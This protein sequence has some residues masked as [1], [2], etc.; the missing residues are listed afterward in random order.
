[1]SRVPFVEVLNQAFSENQKNIEK[2]LDP[3]ETKSDVGTTTSTTRL[4]TATQERCRHP[5]DPLAAQVAEAIA[6]QLPAGSPPDVL[7]Y[8][9][10][11]SSSSSSGV[12][13]GTRTA[14]SR[15]NLRRAYHPALVW[16]AD[17]AAR[18]GYTQRRVLRALRQAGPGQT[19]E[20]LR[21]RIL[22]VTPTAGTVHAAL[23]ELRAAGLGPPRTRP[24]AAPSRAGR[25][26]R[27]RGTAPSP[28]WNCAARTICGTPSRPGRR[29]P[30]SPPGH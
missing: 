27:H 22:G 29:T 13:A 28:T 8:T 18:L 24:V 15:D 19:P 12:A 26:A 3:V 6:R 25:P 14:L 17:P 23:C 20:T 7:V 30:A 5:R 9:G 10:G 2:R 4:Q 11:D 16:V 1:M 21:A